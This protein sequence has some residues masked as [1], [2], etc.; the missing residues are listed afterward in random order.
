MKNIL[1]FFLMFS[2]FS[3]KNYKNLHTVNELDLNQYAGIWYEIAR[4]PNSFESGLMCVTAEYKLNNNEI[5]VINKGF[6]KEKL[7]YKQIKG[8]AWIPNR[9]FPGQLKVQFFWPFSGNYFIKKI[10]NEYETALIPI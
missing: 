4:L 3:C 7:S 5:I 9:N 10:D 2:I 6:S 8:K 1:I